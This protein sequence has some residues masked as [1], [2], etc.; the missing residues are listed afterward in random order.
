[1]DCEKNR[2]QGLGCFNNGTCYNYVGKQIDFIVIFTKKKS[3]FYKSSTLHTLTKP[4]DSWLMT[5]LFS[6]ESDVFQ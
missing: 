1:M 2:C 4:N 5:L 3:I 6:F